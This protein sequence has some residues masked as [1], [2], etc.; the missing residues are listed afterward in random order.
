MRFPIVGR[1]LR[2]RG[3]SALA[4]RHPGV[5][6]LQ[7]SSAQTAPTLEDSRCWELYIVRLVDAP[8][9]PMRAASQ[10]EGDRARKKGEKIDRTARTS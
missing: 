5:G 1:A 6:R 4:R 7:A 8:A 9:S 10:A 2:V 3:T